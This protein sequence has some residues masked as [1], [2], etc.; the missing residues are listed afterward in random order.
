MHAAI[1]W[2]ATKIAMDYAILFCRFLP[3][4]QPP[5]SGN[6]MRMSSSS[7][8]QVTTS[9]PYSIPPPVSMTQ[10]QRQP[11]AMSTGVST[12]Q[13]AQWSIAQSQS[14]PG[15]VSSMRVQPPLS[16]M[17]GQFGDSATMVGMRGSMWGGQ[18]L[19]GM[20]R[21]VGGVPMS[22]SLSQEERRR[23][24][25]R[26]QQEQ[27]IQAQQAR[28]LQ[29]QQQQQQLPVSTMEPAPGHMYP[30]PPPPGPGMMPA[31]LPPAYSQATTY[32]MSQLPPHTMHLGPMNM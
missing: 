23:Q 1:N 13:Q 2:V 6:M 7:Q 32:T 17:P 30:P 24:M 26:M 9:A 14:I 20:Q 5:G 10:Q 29:Q 19:Y 11:Q 8:A 25:L 4:I 27:M 22:T 31:G 12:S 28:R 3:P 15:S 21:P 18:G 16:Q